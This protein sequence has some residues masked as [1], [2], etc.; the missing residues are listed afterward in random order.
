M[1]QSVAAVF[2]ED[3]NQNGSIL[4]GKEVRVLTARSGY[5]KPHLAL[6]AVTMLYREAPEE[7][8]LIGWVGPYSSAAC[9]P[10][11]DLIHGLGQPQISYGCAQAALSNKDRYPVRAFSLLSTQCLC[12][13]L[14]PG[15]CS[16]QPL[17]ALSCCAVLAVFC[18]DLS[19]CHT[20][21]RGI[22][23]ILHSKRLA[24]V[25]NPVH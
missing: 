22:S 7:A 4:P 10:T 6:S 24:K 12:S 15:A 8:T 19:G 16:C 18:S 20:A 23:G 25:C 3:I 21:H 14:W 2:E 9:S 11:Q 1:L 13:A 5:A 17:H